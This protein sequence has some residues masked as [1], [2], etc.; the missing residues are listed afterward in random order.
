M[1]KS[2]QVLIIEDD[3][4]FGQGLQ[5]ALEKIGISSHVCHTPESAQ[6][7]CSHSDFSLIVADCMLPRINGVDLIQ[8]LKPTL[9]EDTKVILMTGVFKDRSFLSEA[10]VKTG[11]VEV[12]SKPF[13]IKDFCDKV[14]SLKDEQIDRETPFHSPLLPFFCQAN[15]DSEAFNEILM[16]LDHLEGLELPFLFSTILAAK[17][18][19]AL[20]LTLPTGTVGEV[21]FAQGRF[22]QVFLNDSKSLLGHLLMDLGFVEPEDLED[23]LAS[24][25]NIRIGEKLIGQLSISPHAVDLALVEQMLLRISQ[26]I[27]RGEVELEVE[28]GKKPT[29]KSQLPP[30]SEK[31]MA[32]LYLEIAQSKFDVETAKEIL[33]PCL[34]LPIQ[35]I[36]NSNDSALDPGTLGEFLRDQPLG[37]ALEALFLRQ[38]LPSPPENESKESLEAIRKKY[39]SLCKS[40]KRK[41]HFEVLGLPSKA[42]SKDIERAYANIKKTMNSNLTL[43]EKAGA[44]ESFEEIIRRLDQ[45]YKHLSDDISRA[46]YK[47]YLEA[48]AQQRLQ[49][50]SHE[51]D[52]A[53]AVFDSGDYLDS[54]KSFQ[55]LGSQKLNFP[56]LKSYLIMAK[57]KIQ[58]QKVLEG[59]L[60]VIPPEHRQNAA[61]MMA[62]AMVYKGS[63]NYPMAIQYFKRALIYSPQAQFPRR[64]IESCERRLA[65]TSQKNNLIG[66]LV[67]GLFS[68][69]SKKK[70]S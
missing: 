29:K 19:G 39:D 31:R 68:G 38:I 12:L 11:A 35:E 40:L 37:E 36:K 34:H 63:S 24:N 41:N 52:L 26:L 58:K 22:D 66:G 6:T 30:I 28:P 25:K 42:V 48:E 70:A 21:Y 8:Q 23:A 61:Y 65:R 50:K 16:D 62:K 13:E 14:L 57:S 54:Y 64:E 5:R 1:E 60:N 44:I 59:E 15:V 20:K 17:W 2:F 3:K 47:K 56:E 46:Q 43:I 27:Q 18:T 51:F 53:V 7:L 69:S 33:A 32:Q 49:N 45:A 55:N 4:S 9:S 10:K 67:D